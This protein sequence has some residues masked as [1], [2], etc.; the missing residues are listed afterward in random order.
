MT[1]LV[2]SGVVRIWCEGQKRGAETRRRRHRLGEEC[3]GLEEYPL[4]GQLGIKGIV[5]SASGI[6]GTTPAE[7][8]NDLVLSNRGRHLSLPISHFSKAIENM[9]P[10]RVGCYRSTL[11]GS[12]MIWKYCWKSREHMPQCPMISLTYKVL[13]T[14]QPTYLWNL[15]A[16]LLTPTVI[17]G[18]RPFRLKFALKVTHQPSKHADFDRFLLITSE[19]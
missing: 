19:P 5:S 17:D 16:L 15:I 10:D 14:S 1:F 11:C 9:E 18:W 7:N 8:E 2:N 6:R 12:E 13:T 4:P 3:G